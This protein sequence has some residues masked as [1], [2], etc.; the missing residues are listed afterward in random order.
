MAQKTDP[1]RN[2]IV[3]EQLLVHLATLAGPG[4][5]GVS[6]QATFGPVIAKPATLHIKVADDGAV[7]PGVNPTEFTE[8]AGRM[9]REKSIGALTFSFLTE[10]DQVFNVRFWRSVDGVLTPARRRDA[11]VLLSTEATAALRGGDRQGA[12][13]YADAWPLPDLRTTQ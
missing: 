8:M 4:R 7:I 10:T 2:R 5:Y 13:R 9:I 3:G 1:R 12:N 11:M 6:V